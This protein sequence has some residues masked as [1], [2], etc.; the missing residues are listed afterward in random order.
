LAAAL[1]GFLELALSAQENSAY[2][3]RQIPA[4][5]LVWLSDA[6]ANALKSRWLAMLP[7]RDPLQ[8]PA[9]RDVALQELIDFLERRQAIA[10]AFAAPFADGD[11]A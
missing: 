11:T 1:S 9:P 4:A 7:R 6:D 2:W 3:L 10:A 5:A 8:D